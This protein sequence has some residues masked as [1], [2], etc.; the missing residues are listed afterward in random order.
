MYEVFILKNPKFIF[1]LGGGGLPPKPSTVRPGYAGWGGE[2][3]PGK[4][5]RIYL[6][7]ILIQLSYTPCRVDIFKQ[8][9]LSDIRQINSFNHVITFKDHQ[10]RLW[11]GKQ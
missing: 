8:P 6:T 7:R 4:S 5:H 11:K 10:D 1:R 2:Q 9:S 3:T